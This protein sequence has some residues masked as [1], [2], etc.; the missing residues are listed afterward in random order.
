MR[1]K[2]CNQINLI[3]YIEI[4]YDF[5]KL[6]V[7]IKT[8]YRSAYCGNRYIYLQVF[9]NTLV[10]IFIIVFHVSTNSYPDA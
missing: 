9:V 10:N 8:I 3:S 2:V 7:S 5:Y 6:Y 4:S 1:R